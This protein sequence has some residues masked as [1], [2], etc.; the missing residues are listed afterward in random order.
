MICC[1]T[2]VFLNAQTVTLTFTGRDVHNQYVPLNRV[3]VSNLTKDWQE[4][5]IWPD[6]EL[7]MTATGIEDV[8]AC[9]GASL[10]LSQ[11]NPNPFDGTT[12]VSLQVGEP[13]DVEMVVTDITGR[14]VAANHYSPLQPGA[15]EIRIT[16]STAGLYFLTARQNGR[17]AAVKMVNRGN[18][19]DNAITVSSLVE[20]CQGA[21]QPQPKIAYRGATDNPFDLGDQME[22]VGFAVLN[23]EEVESAHVAGTQFVSETI[24]LVFLNVQ[25][26]L[27]YP[28]VTDI[29]GNVY[30]TVQI[31]SQ[32]WMKE[33]LRTTRY[34]DGT[35]IPVGT[36]YTTT[37]AYYNDSTSY[38]P[39][40]ERGY[41]YNWLG[42]MH[43]AVSSNAVPSGVQGVCPEGWHLPS[44]AEWTALTNYVSSQ[45]GYV[46][47]GSPIYIAKA[48]ASTSWWLSYGESCC[49]GN[50]S[51]NPNNATGFS[52]VPAGTFGSYGYNDVGRY[53]SF[54][55]ATEFEDYPGMAR[56]VGLENEELEAYH[57]VG[58][59]ERRFS[60]RCLRN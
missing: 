2:V 13:G 20:T 51:A 55:S 42:A 57:A 14:V 28:T 52:A 27:D 53:A 37:E 49:P 39:L 56:Y 30:N 26:C 11:N 19:G 17:T 40:A 44:N 23:G 22:Y 47:G 38:I 25:P 7:V 4:T 58:S 12:F 8:E 21:S 15:H 45:P 59:M 34:E 16:L 50:Q 29:D 32:C 24:E 48:L 1:L 41:L 43:G 31:G 54:W 5:L 46:C 60:V 9:H 35:S 33:N 36:N 10:W 18:G 3:V 6:T